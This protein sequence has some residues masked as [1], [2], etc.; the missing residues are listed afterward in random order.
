[1]RYKKYRYGGKKVP[2]MYAEDG[3]EVNPAQPMQPMQ[4]MNQRP[5]LSPQQMQAMQE[6]QQIMEIM[7]QMKFQNDSLVKQNEL[8]KT[9]IDKTN[10]IDSARTT[11]QTP[12][13]SSSPKRKG[14]SNKKIYPANGFAGNSMRMGGS[15]LPGG[16]YSKKK[17]R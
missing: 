1:M 13:A 14:G 8:L 3:M 10:L 7:Q 12:G 4:S 16:A 2:G 17:R 15:C 5:N 9:Q 11:K 6:Q